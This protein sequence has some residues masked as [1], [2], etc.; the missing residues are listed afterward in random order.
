VKHGGGNI[1]VWGCIA[2][3]G[4]GWII[5]LKGNMD[6]ALIK[7]KDIYFQQDNNPKHT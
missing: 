6:A 2:A 5:R 3:E 1:M 7:K 4:V